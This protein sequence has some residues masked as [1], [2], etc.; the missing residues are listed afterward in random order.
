MTLWRI[1]ATVDDRPGY[2]SVL[3]ASLAL[4]G[5]NILTVQVHTTEAGALDDFLVDA[6]AALTAADLVAAVERGRGRACWV[7]RSEAK[8][9]VDQPTRAL[10]LA[11]RLARDPD[12]LGELLRMLLDADE[13]TW[14]PVATAPPMA[15]ARADAPPRRAGVQGVCLPDPDGGSFEVLRAEPSF[16]PAEFAR[17]QALV[18]LA[19]AMARR[20]AERVTLVLS[21]GAELTLRPATAEDLSAVRAMHERCSPRTRHRRYL[22]GS[23]VPSAARLGRL[24]SP[25]RGMTQVAVTGLSDGQPERVVAVANLVSEGELG[26]VAL[27]VEDAWQHRGV[28]TAMLRRLVRHAAAAGYAALVAHTH[29]DNVRMLRTI[30]RVARSGSVERDG[31]LLTVTVPLVADPAPA[32]APMAATHDGTVSAAP[33][34]PAEV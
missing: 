33:P 3:T 22:A 29:A 23:G 7:A 14:R 17:A 34:S 30:D 10:G 31:S 25:A 4:R 13:V 12:S 19:A 24:L 26:E 16:T 5:V 32:A 11:A 6:P 20:A 2:L 8:G 28:G 9:L 21:D 27:I 18:D 15:A 1:R